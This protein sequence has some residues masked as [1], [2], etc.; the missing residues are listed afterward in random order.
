MITAAGRFCAPELSLLYSGLQML[1]R[2]AYSISLVGTRCSLRPSF[3]LF[4]VVQ[5]DAAIT[6]PIP[7][8][9]WVVLT[10]SLRTS[11][12]MHVRLTATQKGSDTEQLLF[13][14]AGSIYAEYGNSGKPVSSMLTMVLRRF[15]GQGTFDM[16]QPCGYPE[17]LAR[18]TDGID[19]TIPLI[20][21]AHHS[22]TGISLNKLS[23]IWKSSLHSV[24]TSDIPHWCIIPMSFYL[25]APSEIDI[26]AESLW[27]A[28]QP[29]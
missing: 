2:V 23:C 16:Y 15:Y 18:Y 21:H 10:V 12:G 6:S 29:G 7:G 24:S 25:T 27:Y 14:T 13:S 19:R 3:E 20:T 1:E 9:T 26:A 17:L 5:R 11:E 22:V 28:G 4:I 8:T